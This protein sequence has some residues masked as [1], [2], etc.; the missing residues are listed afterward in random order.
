[1]SPAPTRRGLLALAPAAAL[2]PCA[3]AAHPDAELLA[4]CDRFRALNRLHADIHADGALS[5]DEHD[6]AWEPHEPD[7]EHALA[8]VCAARAT[9]LEGI[10]ARGLALAEY[11]PDRVEV[12]H[13]YHDERLLAALLR[14]ALAI[15]GTAP[16]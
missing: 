12:R 6:A 2:A 16:A 5:D 10:V 13:G 3:I 7:L 8:A 14:D 4:A 9:T 1:M 15:A 11:A